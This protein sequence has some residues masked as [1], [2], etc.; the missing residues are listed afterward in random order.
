MSATTKRARARARDL[1]LSL[2]SRRHRLWDPVPRSPDDIFPL[3]VRLVAERGLGVRFEE[4]EEIPIPVQS[5]RKSVP[6]RTAGFI[7]RKERRIVVAQGVPREYRRFTA[8][9]EIA[10]WLLH[11]DLLYH[12]DR[13]LK[14]NERLMPER[15]QVE[16]E[17]D[18]FAAELLMPSKHIVRTYLERFGQVMKASNLDEQAVFWLSG[19]NRRGERPANFAA[20]GMRF[21]SL[22]IATCAA[23]GGRHFVP[24]VERFGVSATATAIRLEE[25]RLIVQ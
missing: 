22:R 21:L 9:H 2:W 19:G 8:A 3:D 15:T 14:G 20:R 10:H 17:A 18:V 23:Y 12:R 5:S 7:D 6:V 16:F 11:P 24:L 4:P 13:P 25:Q 1:L